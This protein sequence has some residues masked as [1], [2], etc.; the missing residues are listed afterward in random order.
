MTTATAAPS[1]LSGPARGAMFV[2]FL[3]SGACGLAYEVVWTRL[4]SREVGHT[5]F[6]LATV[7]AA[8]MGGLAL[9]SWIAMRLVGRLRNPVAWYG[10][11]EIAIGLSALA[12]PWLLQLCHPA[13]G[14]LYRS[15]GLG[16]AYHAA[17][18][19]I[20]AAVILV[21]TTCMGATLSLLAEPLVRRRDELGGTI[22]WLYATNTLGA[23]A[24]AMAAGFVLVPMLGMS[25]TIKAAAV[26]NVVVGVG[27]LLF[28]RG[29]A[30]PVAAAETTAVVGGRPIYLWGMLLSGAIAM[31]NQVVWTRYLALQ[32]GTSVY[33]FTLIVS[34]FILGMAAG[35]MYFGRR[36]DRSRDAVATFG[37][38]QIS[39]GFSCLLLYL[40]FHLLAVGIW[41]VMEESY[42]SFAMMQLRF[43]GAIFS[44][45]FLPTFFLGGTFPT[46]VRGYVPEGAKTGPAVG[47]VYA[48]NTVGA[49]LGSAAGGFIIVPN[50]GIWRAVL[51]LGIANVALGSFVLARSHASMRLLGAVGSLVVAVMCV[52][53]MPSWSE[54]YLIQGA[55][56]Y[57]PYSIYDARRGE[58]DPW[59]SPLITAHHMADRICYYRD[60]AAA[61]VSVLATTN[62]VRSLRIDG[63][64][65]ASNTGDMPTQVLIAQLPILLHPGPVR[66]VMTVGLGSGVSAG[67][68]TVHPGVHVDCVEISPEVVECAR[69]FYRD[70]NLDV[71]DRPD[72][73]RVLV[74]D[75]RSH[76][77][78]T[79]RKYDV[80]CAEPS[81]VFISGMGELF[82]REYYQQCRARL[83]PRGTMSQWVQAYWHT[84]DDI[85]TI[86][87]TFQS[88]F[89]QT[90]MWEVSP[91]ADYLLVGAT[92]GI[93][94]DALSARWTGPVAEEMARIRYMRPAQ[95]F[96]G[97]VAGPDELARWVAGSRL[98]E[99]DTVHLEYSAPKGLYEGKADCSEEIN[100]MRTGTRP[101]DGWP[102]GALECWNARARCLEIRDA[103]DVSPAIRLTQALP[104]VTLD[105]YARGL[106]RGLAFNISETKDEGLEEIAKLFPD[107]IELAI[108][109]AEV[110]YRANRPGDAERSLRESAER[111]PRSAEVLFHLAELLRLTGR[112]AEYEEVE[113]GAW[114]RWRTIRRGAPPPGNGSRK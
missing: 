50:L 55:Y 11:L 101:P 35:S 22:G 98:Q 26:A 48:W 43:F 32:I 91:G 72:K 21:P 76:I 111:F 73:A 33:A 47:R 69:R 67:S 86:I 38:L 23:V 54:D 61:S 51:G 113:K 94:L 53:A 80:I 100:A 87:A 96:A 36:A 81:H 8:F 18:F 84:V 77:A 74:E 82:T 64:V 56:V 37:R 66:E 71:C 93:D 59:V 14:W 110:A 29:A 10:A 58:A 39:I 63:R 97:Y 108:R 79:D 49:I 5:S 1:G 40:L 57:G 45:V 90:W 68:A 95:I 25:A 106:V 17:R 31:A 107:S 27:A 16:V 7:L 44:V 104:L 19:G 89:P 15:E 46:A 41:E 2:A 30:V 65:Q 4:I 92:D 83:A 52:L 109:V 114:E 24:G 99:D 3:L 13:I 112:K 105:P 20:C 70:V 6:A 103:S 9:G 28:S 42:G 75:A 34:A 88:V 12:V 85:R 62:D 60:G 102:E 78:L